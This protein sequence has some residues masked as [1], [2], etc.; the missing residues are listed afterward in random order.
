MKELSRRSFLKGA[1]ASTASV[2][3]AGLAG[4]TPA[5]AEAKGMYTPGTYSAQA[6][7]MDTVTVTMTFSES[8]ITDVVLD[9]PGETPS[10]GQAAAED[11][12]AALLSGQTA[13]IDAV[14]GATITSNAVA[15]AANKCIK[16]AKGEIPIEVITSEKEEADG[17]WLGQEPQ[18]DE[19][20]I[21]A[22]YETEILVIGCGT[23]GMF[24]VA[25]AAE[26]GAKVI[27]IDRFP[28]GVGIRDDL[29][30]IDS[31]YQKEWG[32][33]IDKFDYITMA[34]QYAAG[35]INQELVKLFC[36]KSGAVIDW[37]GDRLAE[38]GVELWH[39]SGDSEDE[40]RYHHFATGHSPRW[41]GSDDGTGKTL[42]GNK[43]LYDY[44]TKLGAEFHYNTK[45]I[46]LVKDGERVTGCIAENGDGQVVRYTATKG[47]VV[48]TGGYSL[49]YEMMEAL[50][51][52]NLRIIGRNGSEP[53]AFGDGIKAC[54]WAGAKMDETHSMMM[55][56]RCAL[57]PDQETGVETAKSGDNGFFWMG[58]QPWLKVN[59]DGKRFFNESGTYEGI[60]HADEYQKG[61]VHYTI[62]DSNW[63]TYATQFKMHGCSRLYP[64]EN[65][66]DPNIPYQAIESGMLPGLIESGFVMQADTVE[67]LAE[68]LGLP[69]EQLA[70]T[71]ERYNQLA[72]AGNDEDFGKEAFRL[73][74]VDKGPFYGA[75]NTG[76]VLCTM[77]GIQIDTNMNAIDP[78]GNAIAGL[79]VVGND[80]GCYFANTYPNLSTG[81]ACGRTVTFGYLLGKQL[82]KA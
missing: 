16:Q 62:F 71:V 33:K 41:T 11:L 4:V 61:H 81:M 13:E 52:W 69:A 29:G 1:L 40:A 76:Y 60:L 18:I 22:E 56:D 46:K 30:A 42:D 78:E 10:I 55:F 9:M 5:F 82:A 39:E 70:K 64:F 75:K 59:A 24:V 80:S 77:D 45:M 14:S 26:E 54:L 6:Q 38:R 35:H 8:A 7:G 43:V 19:S 36:E 57:R 27:G 34:T 51:P 17:D 47:T 65:G 73:T 50:Q 32:T 48:A 44:A 72:Y 49:N 74:P 58:S 20:E 15:K 68:K 66:A 12:K 37:Y 67:E 31:R 23:G 3:A 79:Y 21:A 2:A 53:G 28:T 25:S 63:T